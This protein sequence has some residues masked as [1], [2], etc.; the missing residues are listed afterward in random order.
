MAPTH[1]TRRIY[2]FSESGI[3]AFCS[4]LC[5]KFAKF[6]RFTRQADAD[7]ELPVL[8]LEFLHVRIPVIVTTDS[9]DRDH[10]VPGG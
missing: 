3:P 6:E 2:R 9:G 10:S 5:G 7:L 4:D 8:V 1:H